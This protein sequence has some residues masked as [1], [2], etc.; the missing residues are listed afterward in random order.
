MSRH[1]SHRGFTLIEVLLA[2]FIIALGVLGL[3]A[4]FAGAAKQQ[5]ISSQETAAV[6]AARS[7]EGGLSSG[8][9]GLRSRPPEPDCAAG[10][11]NDPFPLGVW[12]RLAMHPDQH[13]LSVNPGA[14]A[15]GPYFLVDG[16]AI[17]L[18]TAVPIPAGTPEIP[19]TNRSPGFTGGPSGEFA[20]S[21]FEL[22]HRR[23]DPD[24]LRFEVTYSKVV[25]DTVNFTFERD[26]NIPPLVFERQTGATY[27]EPSST[28]FVYPLG[29]AQDQYPAGVGSP[30]VPECNYLYVDLQLGPNGSTLARV[31]T[32][33]I[34]KV[35][36][37]EN[38]NTSAR[39]ESVR[40]LS[41]QWRNDQLV[42]LADRLRTRSDPS[43]PGGRLADQCYSVLFRNTGTGS[44]AMVLSYQ[45][46]ATSA[47]AR[48]IPP[49]THTNII[50]NVS[51]IRQISL[52]LFRD[53]DDPQQF[54]FRV[55]NEEDLWVIAPGQYLLIAGDP[56]PSPPEPGSDRAVRVIRQVRETAAQGSRWRGYIDRMPR[57]LDRAAIPPGQNQ[58][59]PFNVL[60]IADTIISR[61]D[62]SVWKLTPLLASDFAVRLAN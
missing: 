24:S 52:N 41:Y 16:H 51:P 34:G 20:T 12:Q 11:A 60:G 31:T 25:E 9:G 47:S 8:F 3:L 15:C 18:F 5:Q 59:G 27:V 7:A 37:T 21:T 36:G 58:A 45:L 10:S 48:F 62:Q 50:Q 6:F 22:P 13:F 28:E 26:Y 53:A 61:A 54:Y 40:V 35:G 44:Q 23:I 39:I 29:G 19:G 1:T 43:A 4:L 17:T 56:S 55:L 46:T 32:M 57:I 38:L 30:G 42:S 49:E 14:S 2:T 33:D